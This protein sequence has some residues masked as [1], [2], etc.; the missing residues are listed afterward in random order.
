M[1]TTPPEIDQIG[2]LIKAIRD[3]VHPVKAHETPGELTYVIPQVDMRPASLLRIN[4]EDGLPDPL[5]KRGTITVFDPDSF[6]KIV[7]RNLG[8]L[9]PAVY[10]DT[11]VLAPAVIAVMNDHGWGD[12]RIEISFRRTPQW[13]KWTKLDGQFIQQATFTEFVEDNL[14]DIVSPEPAQMLEIVSHLEATRTIAFRSGFRLASG[15]VQLVHDQVDQVKVGNQLEVPAEFKIGLAPFMGM[16]S[17]E[18][19]ARFRYRITEGKLHLGFRLQ[20]IE[21]MMEKIIAELVAAVTK[22]LPDVPVVQGLPRREG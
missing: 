18:I 5:R 14:E 9:D 11:N 17:Y 2:T 22:G 20:R 8:G 12:F 10:V 6:I 16:P 21:T 4:K 7:T 3:G 13:V 15:T 19:P 1:A